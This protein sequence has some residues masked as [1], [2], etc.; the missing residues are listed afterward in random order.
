[1]KKS[2]KNQVLLLNVCLSE[3]WA[4]WDDDDVPLLEILVSPREMLLKSFSSI[5]SSLIFVIAAF[6]D[7][8][9]NLWDHN[10]HSEL[11]DQ[12]YGRLLILLEANDLLMLIH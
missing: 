6:S 1:M 8:F 5:Y 11:M 12:V 3:M 7:V 10:S 4:T 9:G 2:S